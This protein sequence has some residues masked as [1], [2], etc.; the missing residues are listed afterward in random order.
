MNE[1]SSLITQVFG[2]GG[3]DWIIII[4]IGRVL[5]F[6]VRKIHELARSFG[7]ASSEYEKARIQAK[8][9][10]QDIRSQGTN[11]VDREKLETIAET[12]GN[13]Y[14]NKSDD[15]LRMAIESEINRNKNKL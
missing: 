5:I 14:T 4:V 11:T 10:L 7:K 12:L 15:E 9:E 8:K 6:G 2:V 1:L 3:I 13:N